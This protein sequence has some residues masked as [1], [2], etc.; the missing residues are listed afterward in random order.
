M[1]LESPGFIRGEC[2]ENIDSSSEPNES[3]VET[4]E[5]EPE[6][7]NSETPTESE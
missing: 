1:K 4:E 3:S 2:Q 6:A 5:V 7:E